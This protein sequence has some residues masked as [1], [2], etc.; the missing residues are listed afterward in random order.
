MAQQTSVEQQIA[1]GI[2]TAL[3]LLTTF[4]VYLRLYIRCIL[5]K[6]GSAGWDDLTV[7]IAWV[8]SN[9]PLRLCAG[10]RLTLHAGHG[11]GGIDSHVFRY[12]L[13][14]LFPGS[15]RRSC[16]S[17][18]RHVSTNQGTPEIA[19]GLGRHIEELTPDEIYRFNLSLFIVVHCYNV[20]LNTVKISF[21]AQYYRIFPD[22]VIRRICAAFALFCFVWMII[23]SILYS[24][25]CVPIMYLRPAM[26]AVCVNTL[27]TCEL[28]LHHRGVTY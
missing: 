21:L 24:F 20:G 3:L 19:A 2:T 28:E 16:K 17:S 6:G 15:R 11:P 4:V 7:F 23:Q 25:S 18:S 12:V 8:S 22:K 1:I 10:N 9:L 14:K 5:L 26:S 13:C 27:V